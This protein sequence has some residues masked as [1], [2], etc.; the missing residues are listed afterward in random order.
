MEYKSVGCSHALN[1]RISLLASCGGRAGSP[2]RVHKDCLGWLFLFRYA[3]FDAPFKDSVP[4]ETSV[5]AG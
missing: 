1:E 2:L 4:D 3:K 5:G